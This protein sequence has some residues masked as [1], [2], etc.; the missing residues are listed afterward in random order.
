MSLES[1]LARIDRI[2]T[3]K[4][5]LLAVVDIVKRG[6]YF[7]YIHIAGIDAG[8]RGVGTGTIIYTDWPED[9]LRQYVQEKW[10]VHDPVVVALL[11][12]RA[13]V[14]PADA[15]EVAKGDVRAEEIA[16]RCQERSL[17]LPTVVP[18]FQLQ[19]MTGSVGFAR[20][21]PFSPD[22]VHFLSVVAPELHRSFAMDERVVT[23]P[24]QQLTEREI[25][26]LRHASTGM[27][28]EEISGVMPLAAATVT[29]HLRNAAGKL[30]AANRV[31]AIAEAI[32]RGIID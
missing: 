21:Q 23:G 4:R 30:N 15:H 12:K 1:V 10:Y 17:P 31:Q 2:R 18:V 27:T 9:F 14:H 3:G 26:C 11:M 25:E 13:I 20:H 6:V 19:R 8:R 7:E 24:E 29:A 22:E 32:R 28:S 16:R 5:N